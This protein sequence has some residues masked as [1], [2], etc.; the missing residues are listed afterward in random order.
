MKKRAGFV[1]ISTRL[2]Q[3]R[4]M[5]RGRTTSLTIRLTPAERR[6]LL[7]WQR[8]RTLPAG[9]ARRAR[10]LLL[11]SEGRTITDIAATV[12]VSRQNVYKWIHRF[13]EERLEGLHAKPGPG[14]RLGPLP[15][16]LREQR[17]MDAG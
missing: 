9:L 7:A 16:D 10:M 4:C 8:S 6:T 5:A 14:H 13:L 17:D 11:L 3:G 1:T 12:G 2:T 15:P